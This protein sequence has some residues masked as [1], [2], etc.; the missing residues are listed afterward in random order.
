M[1]ILKKDFIKT[2]VFAI[3]VSFIA[4][5]TVLEIKKFQKEEETKKNQSRVVQFGSNQIK[6][7]KFKNYILE[8][9][10]KK[11]IWKIVSPYTDYLNY[12]VTEEWVSKGLSQEGRNLSD[13]EKPLNWAQFSLDKELNKIVYITDSGEKTLVQLSEK[14]AF[15]GSTYLRVGF[16]ETEKLYSSSNEWKDVFSKKIESLRS[17]QLFN[18]EVP[19]PLSLPKKISFYKK[20]KMYL[21]LIKEDIWRS[22]DFKSWNFDEAKVNSYIQELKTYLHEGFSEKKVDLKDKISSLVINTD[23]GEELS[24][25][26]YKKGYAVS[27]YRSEHTLSVDKTAK[28]ALIVDPLDLRSFKDIDGNTPNGDIDQLT[29][30]VGEKSKAFKFKD[31]IW[32]LGKNEKQQDSFNG[33]RVFMFLN[34]LKEINYKRFISDKKIIFK[35][36]KK[37]IYL[38]KNKKN[39][40][41]YSIGQSIKCKEESQLKQCVLISTNQL[42]KAYAIALEQEIND[43]FKFK[44]NEEVSR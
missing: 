32:V 12:R 19:Y 22:N 21:S 27:S 41:R 33:A 1:R 23:T 42:Q 29:I 30:R 7:V 20:G 8:R 4:V 11:F 9:D 13:G 24:L 35:S 37:R 40:V 34:K 25:N 39:L 5:L 3:I 18:W 16:K 26:F 28:N 14:E 44:F 38:I 17:L 10:K 43:I 36:A 31:N 15:D 6:Q 2:V